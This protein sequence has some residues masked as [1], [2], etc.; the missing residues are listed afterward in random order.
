MR[1][2][3]VIDVARVGVELT[4][5]R[6]ARPTVIDPSPTPNLGRADS[7]MQT[8]TLHLSCLGSKSDGGI[9]SL[10]NELPCYIFDHACKTGSSQINC[11]IDNSIKQHSTLKIVISIEVEMTR[12]TT[13]TMSQDKAQLL[14]IP[15]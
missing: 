8:T 6:K 14:D 12:C 2:Q 3:P 11:K 1:R 13:Y 4:K 7:R 9:Y 5:S 10:L 15:C